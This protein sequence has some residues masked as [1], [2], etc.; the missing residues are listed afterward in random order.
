MICGAIFD[1]DGTILDSMGRQVAKSEKER[2]FAANMQ[3][4]RYA[5]L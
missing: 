5:P 2:C 1:A 4:R 3:N